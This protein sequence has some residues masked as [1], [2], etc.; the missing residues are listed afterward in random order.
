M[1]KLKAAQQR[2]IDFIY[3][4]DASI[5]VAPTGAGKTVICLTAINELIKAGVIKRVIVAVPQSALSSYVRA[6][7]PLTS[8]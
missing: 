2:A 8:S 1:L 4:Q 3:N 5:L 6:I 7:V